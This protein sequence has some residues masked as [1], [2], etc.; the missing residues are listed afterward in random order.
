MRPERA[1]RCQRE[2]A[3]EM[4]CPGDPQAPD[5]GQAEHAPHSQ[6]VYCNG[7]TLTGMSS[8]PLDQAHQPPPRKALGH[9]GLQKRMLQG[10]I[11]ACLPRVPAISSIWLPHR[12]VP[13]LTALSVCLLPWPPT[14]FS[15]APAWPSL[16]LSPLQTPKS[17]QPGS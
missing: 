16:F 12:A 6:G 15:P 1:K 11:F 4:G 2:P 7:R 13:P 10:S 14:V 3:V 5:V 8:K 9:Q 17:Q